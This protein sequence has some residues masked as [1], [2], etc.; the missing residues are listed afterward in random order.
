MLPIAIHRLVYRLSPAFVRT[1]LKDLT[2]FGVNRFSL[3]LPNG[4]TL[5]FDHSECSKILRRFAWKHIHGYEPYTIRLFHALARRAFGVLD[6]GAYFGLYALIA[7]KTNPKAIV[8]AFEPVPQN[9][10]LLRHFLELNNCAHVFVHPIAIARESGNATLYIPDQRKSALPPTG[11]LKN[12]F[13][14][15]ERFGG[16]S[17]QAVQVRT[18][19]LDSMIEEEF[20]RHIDLVKIDTEET[21]HDVILSGEKMFQSYRPDIV[22]EII[23]CNPHVAE[24]L[25]F[26]R[27]LGY[28]FFH[29][30]PSGLSPF[31][32]HRPSYGKQNGATE[33]LV[34]CEIFCTCR[35]DS[36][37]PRY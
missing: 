26:L 15:G 21:E 17:A 19:P 23:F 10:E 3:I 25:A 6:I 34:Y 24:A 1:R 31:D 20:I 37:L 32:E 13:L 28:R 35:A 4:Q 36:D 12:C 30:D 7:A 11:S 2:P 22:M 27:K 9:L 8:H 14:P 29:I 33:D 5:I 18:K 16:R